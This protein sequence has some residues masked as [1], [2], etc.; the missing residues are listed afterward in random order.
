M[1]KILSFVFAISVMASIAVQ[2]NAAED[3]QR[4]PAGRIVTNRNQMTTTGG[5][6]Q[7]PGGTNSPFQC[8]TKYCFCNSPR[9]CFNMGALGVCAGPVTNGGAGGKWGECNKKQ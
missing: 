6:Y 2:A 5:V 7:P 8:N 3:Y 9:D 1:Y 4:A